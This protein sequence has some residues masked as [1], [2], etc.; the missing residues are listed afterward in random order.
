MLPLFRLDRIYCRPAGIL[1]RTFT[2][3]SAR[4]VSDHLPVVADVELSGRA[5]GRGGSS[6]S[7]PA[8]QREGGVG[9]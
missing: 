8:M 2:D 4:A 5:S 3:V 6:G 9:T 7:S 1:R